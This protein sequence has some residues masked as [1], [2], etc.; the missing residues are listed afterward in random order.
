MK[1]FSTSIIVLLAGALSACAGL[2]VTPIGTSKELD[3]AAHGFRYYQPAP[4]LFVYSDGKGGLVSQI[5]YL[6]D[7]TQKMSVQPYAYLASNEST[8]QFD[9]GMLTQ[10]AA[11]VDETVVPAAA[12]DSLAKV[13]AAA[14]KAA[15]NVPEAANETKVPVPYLFK[16][17][18]KGNLIE[19]K[20]GPMNG[21]ALTQDGKE[22]MVIH[23]TIATK[24]GN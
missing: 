3:E 5:K 8:L 24:G 15:M 12:L 4:Y 11:V 22:K 9:A 2:N 23:A 16:I 7:T 13:L 21:A 20:G 10:A 17:V 6:P 19:L 18:V 14:A 1:R